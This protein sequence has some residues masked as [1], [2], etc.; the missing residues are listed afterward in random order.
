[1]KMSNRFLLRVTDSIDIDYS[2]QKPAPVEAADKERIVKDSKSYFEKKDVILCRS[3]IQLYSYAEVLRFGIG[4]PK[5]KKDFYQ[6]YRP[7]SVL[8]GNIDKMANI[9]ITKEHPPEFINGENW[10]R[11]AHGYT[12][13]EVAAVPLGDGEIGIKSKLV[14]STSAIYNYYLEGNEEV[15]L[16]YT[17]MNEWVDNSDELG[18]DILMVG[19]ED[20]NHLA[21]TAAGR[22]GSRVSVIDSLIGGITMF[23][24]GLFH[25]LKGKGKTADSATPFSKI[26]FDSLEASKSLTGEP[27]E[28]E[29]RRV[30]DSLATL[31][32]GENKT[33]L[34]DAVSDCYKAIDTA[35]EN[36][37]SVSKF[38]DSVY[39]KA[40]DETMKT[41]DGAIEDEDGKGTG[42]KNV[43]DSDPE[44]KQ[45]ESKDESKEDKTEASDDEKSKNMDS[46]KSVITDALAEFSASMNASIDEKIQ[47]GIK[48]AL[49]IETN[50]DPAKGG[51]VQDSNAPGS[52][53]PI[54]DIANFV[55]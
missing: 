31:K 9:P 5:V 43:S 41:V 37:D 49:G 32:D 30:V 20:V 24:T 2:H 47:A 17:S 45:E 16:G 48:A 29:V 46:I 36:K 53:V 1:M 25:F 18:Y 10:Q 28:K 12:G 14:F 44:E 21:V 19:I 54:V 35:V 33:L 11:Y 3:G 40:E 55:L 4:H 27:L 7:A 52:A 34:I 42:T 6:V 13:S 23:K 51:I 38:L 8:I 26:V 39:K 22:G 50:P 15:S